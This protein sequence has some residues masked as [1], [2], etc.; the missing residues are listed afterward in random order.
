MLADPYIYT[1]MKVTSGDDVRYY[2]LP[3]GPGN[4]MVIGIQSELV[5]YLHQNGFLF[6]MTKDKLCWK[7]NDI[8]Y[9][10]EF[11]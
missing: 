5:K 8:E 4:A 11:S 6:R 10:V 1:R 9:M 7:E 3:T 2:D